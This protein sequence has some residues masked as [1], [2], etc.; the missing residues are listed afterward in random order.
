M[1]YTLLILCNDKK[2]EKNNKLQL[3]NNTNCFIILPSLSHRSALIASIIRDVLSSSLIIPLIVFMVSRGNV[4]SIGKIPSGCVR[5]RDIVFKMVEISLRRVAS[6]RWID[7]SSK[8]GLVHSMRISS[9]SNG[10]QSYA[11]MLRER[12]SKLNIFSSFPTMVVTASA[13]RRRWCGS[14]ASFSAM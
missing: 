8:S 10:F 7:D 1:N 9:T 6:E 11:S 12:A 14:T 13:R 5:H 4:R 2:K 3:Y